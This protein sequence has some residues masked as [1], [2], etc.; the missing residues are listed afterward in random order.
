MGGDV[1]FLFIG[2]C[3]GVVVMLNHRAYRDGK[4][5]EQVDQEVRNQ[6]TF[7]KNLSESLRIDVDFYK[8]KCKTLK[9]KYGQ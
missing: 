6:L 3:F 7:Y 4:T 1:I 5:L 8:H 2:F 9:D